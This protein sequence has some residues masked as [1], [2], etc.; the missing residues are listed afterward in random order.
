M[1]ERRTHER[2]DPSQWSE[3]MRAVFRELDAKHKSDNG[4]WQ[5]NKNLNAGHLLTTL[6]LVVSAFAWGSGID[7]RLSVTESD[8]GHNKEQISRIESQVAQRLDR[9]ER[10][11]DR[12]VEGQR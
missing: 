11:L 1:T 5:F 4:G 9:I 6:G 10:K 7:N 8:T 12:L 2:A 3:E